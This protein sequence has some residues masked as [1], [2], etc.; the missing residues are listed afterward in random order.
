MQIYGETDSSTKRYE[1]IARKYHATF[2]S[3]EMSFFSAPGRTELI[4]NHV[5]HNGGKVLAASIHMDTICA[6]APN[7]TDLIHIVSEGYRNEITIRISELSGIPKECGT[8]SLVAGVLIGAKQ[9]GF[10]IGGFN[11]YVSSTVIS[12][13]GVSSSASFEMLLCTIINHFFNQHQMNVIDCAQ[14][15]QFAENHFWKKASGLLDQMACA[16]GGCILLDFS[17]DITYQR[18]DFSFEEYGYKLY[19][20]DTGKG[21]SDLSREYSQIPKEMEQV[22]KILGVSQLGSSRMEDLLAHWNAAQKKL[23]NDRALLRALHFYEENDR[24]VAAASA[25]SRGDYKKVVSL[26]QESGDSS[27]KLLQNCYMA[28]DPTQQQIPHTLALTQLFLRRIGDGCVRVH[29]GGFAGVILSVIPRK[30]ADQ[31]V[32]FLSEFI[33][34]SQIHPIQIRQYGA[35]A[36]PMHEK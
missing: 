25:I 18:L 5:D 11:A 6:A 1:N 19:I 14:I 21:H 28:Q 7:Q 26:L 31:Y 15:G 10:C 3:S 4:G 29:G 34:L 35:I 23:F 27:W 9:F 8:I 32:S 24:V 33:D 36:L 12:A 2:H 30:E 20:V 17:K 13:A 16:V 22:A